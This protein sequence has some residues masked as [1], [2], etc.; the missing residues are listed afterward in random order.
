MANRFRRGA[1]AYDKQGRVYVV[2]DIEDGIVYCTSSNGMETEFPETALTNEEEWNARSEGKRGRL[3][4]RLKLS[5]I[6]LAPTAKL[7]RSASEQALAKIERLLPGI[8]D[9]AAVAVAKRIMAETGDSDLVATLSIAKCR[10]VFDAAPPEIRAGL[11]AGAMGNPPEVLV[12]AGR[13]GDNLMR[14]MLDKFLAANGTEFTG[15]GGRK[16]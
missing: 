10:E 6:Y 7:D 15:F 16:R 3:Y 8:L 4:D 11:L 14:A 2:E 9:F 12:G 13:L 5:R 1:N